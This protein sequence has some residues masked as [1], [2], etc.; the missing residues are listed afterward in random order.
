MAAI[1]RTRL[2]VAA[3]LELPDEHYHEQGI[4]ELID[5]EIFVNSPKYPHQKSLI[6]ILLKLTSEIKT[7]EWMFAPMSIEFDDYNFPQP[8]LFWVSGAGS[9]CQLGDDGYWHGAP[10]FILEVLSPGT[11]YNDRAK[12]YDL[13]QH[14]GV[15]EYWLMQ[16]NPED[17]FIEAYALKEGKFERIGVFRTGESFAS[18]LFGVAFSVSD[19]FAA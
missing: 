2:T 16:P 6:R 11:E 5:G 9:R 15:R 10:D 19:F 12:K 14:H 18:P 7:G 17:R 8:D 1:A 3:F 4:V 13:Y